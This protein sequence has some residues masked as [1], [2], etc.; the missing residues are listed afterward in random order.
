MWDDDPDHEDTFEYV[1]GAVA[2]ALA[3]MGDLQSALLLEDVERLAMES[4]PRGRT[5]RNPWTQDGSEWPVHSAVYYLEVEPYL[6][7]RFTH[8][9]L[10]RIL[11][12]MRDFAQRCH[13]AVP[14]HL[15]TRLALPRI[16]VQTWR[17]GLRQQYAGDEVTNSARRERLDPESP[18][19]DGLT[20][21]NTE[22]LTVYQSIVR[23][24]ETTREDKTF[25]VS[26]LPGTRIRAGNVWTPDFLL[27]GNGRAMLI[28][29]DGP[30]HAKAHRRA[31]D[32]T[33][34]AQ[35]RRC[36]VQVRRVPVEYTRPDRVAE[37][38]AWLKVEIRDG[39]GW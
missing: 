33:R 27:M 15:E 6:Q 39:L 14:E 2:H 23:L 4:E 13:Q 8:E 37:L 22:E 12:V 28:E 17:E 26:P 24:Q 11:P 29:V 38:D 9:V 34:D 1:L 32:D 10:G 31:D 25:A 21:S 20:F 18:V 7:P 30:Q 5:E 16:E 3:Q 19:R 35:W 36:G